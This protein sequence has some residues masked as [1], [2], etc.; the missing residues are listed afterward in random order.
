MGVEKLLPIL[1][2]ES[3]EVAAVLLSK[4]DVARAAELLGKLPGPQ[5][6][7]ITYAAFSNQR[8]HAGC[9]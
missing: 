2:N 4:I 8:G 1:E 6:R 5:A 7:R 9:G 3:I